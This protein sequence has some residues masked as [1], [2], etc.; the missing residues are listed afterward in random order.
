MPERHPASAHRASTGRLRF[1]TSPFAIC[2]A[3]ALAVGVAACTDDLENGGAACPALCPTQPNTFRDTLIDAVELDTTIGNF[4][5]LGLAS[6]VLLANRKDTVESNVVLRFD[7]YPRSFLPNNNGSDSLPITTVDSAYVRVIIDST[8]ARGTAQVELQAF[9]VD[10]TDTNASSAVVRSL[11]RADR[12][13][14][15]TPITT[16]AARDT[17]RIPISKAW[18]EAKIAGEKRVRIGLRLTGNT[19][20]Q[21]RIVQQV[22]GIASPELSFDPAT[23]TSYI[24]YNVSPNTAVGGTS[25]EELLAAAVSPLLI[26]GTS[27][28]GAQTLSVGGFPS[29]RSY[30]RFRIPQNILDS[31]T[32][33][34]AELLLTQ[35]PGNGIDGR[36][37]LGVVPLIGVSSDLVTDIRRAMEL[38]APGFFTTP[39][40]DSL[41]VAPS[42]SGLKTLNM[43]GVFRNWAAL[44]TS[45]PRVLVLR[46]S[47]EGAEP[48]EARFFSMKAP[49]S[50]RPRLRV[51][52]LP[53]VDR[54]LP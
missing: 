27:E 25:S 34:R 45:V 1:I 10:T 7:L 42:D 2:A 21:V 36:D 38:A 44:P 16:I 14:G 33:V 12:L 29:H 40:L 43:L 53:R 13:I 50:L 17:V 46:S 22:L 32:V 35:R 51:T 47:N 41:L 24:S 6:S 26:K 8:G 5:A 52:Y 23:D 15:T 3:I 20:A 37:T 39:D 11:F 54:A 31:S 30:M 19:S 18:L 49:A 28:A 4:P 9:D 48:A